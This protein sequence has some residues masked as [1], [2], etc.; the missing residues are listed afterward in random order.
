MAQQGTIPLKVGSY[1]DLPLLISVPR[2]AAMLGISRS[3]GYRCA[4]L[5]ELPIRRLGGRVYVV[6]RRLLELVE[7]DR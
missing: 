7:A 5:G 2:A 4:A 6:T 3:A 1:A